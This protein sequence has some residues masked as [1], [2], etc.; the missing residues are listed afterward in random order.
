MLIKRKILMIYW[1]RAAAEWDTPDLVKDAYELAKNNCIPWTT[2]IKQILD[3]RG[4][5]YVWTNPTSVDPVN[6]IAE[7]EERLTGHFQ[8]NWEL[9]GTAGHNW[10]AENIASYK[11]IKQLEKY[12][13]LYTSPLEGSSH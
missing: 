12:L 5:S 7:L 4:F 3:D 8:Q 1:L 6:L 2:Y 13:E 10:K 9:R 11:V